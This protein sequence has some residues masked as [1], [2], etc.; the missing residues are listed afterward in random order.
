[1]FGGEISADVYS[2][3]NRHVATKNASY[4]DWHEPFYAVYAYSFSSDVSFLNYP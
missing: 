2:G 3:P 1:M 4:G